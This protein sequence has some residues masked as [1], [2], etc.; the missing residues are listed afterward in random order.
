MQK[1]EWLG[2]DWVYGGK[3]ITVQPVRC[4]KAING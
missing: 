1:P 4:G 2:S 3:L